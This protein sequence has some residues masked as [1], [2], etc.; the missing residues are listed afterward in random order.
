MINH[1]NTLGIEKSA[2]AR[3]I[4][5][6]YFEL[7]KQ[8]PPERFPDKFKEIRAAYDALS[9]EETRAKYDETAE[10]PQDIVF[11]YNQAQLARQQGRHDSVT[12]VIEMILQ[13]H[14]ELSFIR[15]EYARSLEA[16]G[17]TGKAIEVWDKLC[18]SERDNAKYTVALADCYEMRGWRKKAIDAYKR[19]IAI[20]NGDVECWESLV[21]CHLAGSEYE[22][23]AINTLMAVDILKKKGKESAYLYSNAVIYGVDD[24]DSL[25]EKYIKDILS[26][27]QSG[28][29]NIED[30][31]GA[32]S[33][34]LTYFHTEG[35]TRFFPYIN[36]IAETIPDIEEN[37][38]YMLVHAQRDY[39]AAA[40]E[41]KGFAFL[42]CDLLETLNKDC[43]CVNCRKAITSMEYDILTDINTYRPQIVRLKNEYPQ[44]YSLHTDFFNEVIYTRDPDKMLYKRLNT[45]SKHGY[46][47]NIRSRDNDEA[48]TASQTVRR[49]G[50]KIG[51]NDPCPCGSGKKY[52]K[53]CGG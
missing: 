23:A 45:L 42:F 25:T 37:V 33:C 17:K 24:D 31:Q 29:A 9:N 41:E 47:S 11:L 39:E 48:P 16:L 10:L 49:E 19:A 40:L 30:I 43:G 38:R 2:D 52:K 6:A 20:D 7:V 4:K 50:P 46:V 22:E 26:M 51:R 1:Y 3:Q 32:I 12:K 8:F 21:E 53:C 44:L 18:A 36:E 27:A 34:L 15:S 35:I 13:I 5:R 14:P 28:K